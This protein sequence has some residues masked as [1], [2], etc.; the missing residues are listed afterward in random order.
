MLEATL[1][2]FVPRFLA[3][4]GTGIKAIVKSILEKLTAGGVKPVHIADFKEFFTIS[5]F[6]IAYILFYAITV[7]LL[8]HFVNKSWKVAGGLTKTLRKKGFSTIMVIINANY[9]VYRQISY[10]SSGFYM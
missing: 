8:M 7:P 3:D 5:A 10:S 6:F 1:V 2:S 9:P 4:G